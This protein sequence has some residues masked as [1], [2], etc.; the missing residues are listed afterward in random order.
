VKKRDA[1]DLVVIEQPS[2]AILDHVRAATV[3]RIKAR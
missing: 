3:E 1:A 2:L